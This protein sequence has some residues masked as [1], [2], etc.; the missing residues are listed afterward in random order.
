MTTPRQT[1]VR[2]RRQW[3]RERWDRTQATLL[4]A[5]LVGLAYLPIVGAIYMV[6][7]HLPG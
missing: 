4:I 2:T 6:L 1:R 3:E 7:A 5:G